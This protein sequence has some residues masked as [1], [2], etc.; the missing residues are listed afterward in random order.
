MMTGKRKNTNLPTESGPKKQRKAID[1][2]IKLK[3]LTRTK[4]VRNFELLLTA[5]ASLIQ[6]PL[7]LSRTKGASEKWLNYGQEL[8]RC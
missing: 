2:D 6:L 8:E 3:S 5:V 4:E 1:L 7:Q